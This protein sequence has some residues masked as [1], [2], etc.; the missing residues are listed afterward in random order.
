MNKKLLSI[1]LIGLLLIGSFQAFAFKKDPNIISDKI[2]LSEL[3]VAEIEEFAIIS[4][5]NTT[6][7]LVEDGKPILPQ[8][9]KNYSVPYGS[10][11]T[12]VDVI[13]SDYHKKIIK[14]PI[15]PGLIAIPFG[16]ENDQISI[17]QESPIY[18]DITEF[19]QEKFEYF[20][21]AGRIDN[22]PV[23]LISLY[24]YPVQYEPFKNTVHYYRNIE[25]IIKYSPP[26]NYITYPDEFDLLVIS[27]DDFSSALQPLIDHKN[28][29]GVKSFLKTTEEIYSEYP[30]VDKPEKIKYFIKD[31]LDSYGIKFVLLVGGLKSIFYA[32]P[33]D[34]RNQ[35]TEDWYLPVRYANIITSYDPGLISD[36]YYADIYDSEGNF[37]S[38]DSNEDGLFAS[39]KSFDRNKDIIDLVPEVAVGRLACRN[40]E[41]VNIVVNKIITYETTSYGSEW[42]KNF[43]LV[44][45]DTFD[46]SNNYIEGEIETQKSYDYVFNK[47]YN[48]IRIW[49]SNRDLGGLVPES[50]DIISTI[51][52]GAG[53]V[54]FA[55]HGSPEIWNTH[56]VGGPFERSERAEGIS[57][58]HM[59]KLTNTNEQPIVV[60][61]GC[62]N[63]QFNVTLT[64]FV[65]Y[66]IY[67]LY[68]LTGLEIFNRFE[69]SV[70]TPLPECFSWFFVRQKNGG[71]IATIG[72]TGTG[73]GYTG[74]L[75]DLDG[76]GVDDPDVIEKYGGYIE[77]LFFKSIGVNNVS[78]LGSAW[79]DAITM[80]LAVY[81]G[82]RDQIDAK[83]IE[84]WVL[85]GDPSLKIGG[86]S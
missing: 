29:M 58:Y 1:F 26:R 61:G 14:N 22:N 11:I 43:I 19:P 49:A 62:H 81:P 16:E 52:A 3:Q 15:K 44:G 37:S 47:G 36:L 28:N 69:G 79:Q 60:I 86:Y 24:C 55:G 20:T 18:E 56:W 71:A 17:Q 41:E 83:S 84:Q 74:N 57:W 64:T 46:E 68:E 53:L 63:S 35:G 72:N 48:A 5:S 70:F 7:F 32:K 33:R 9:I 78:Y 76:D 65:N 31:A 23:M 51:S 42:E 66:W 12:F 10:K 54:H 21:S 67:K 40:I 8:I 2:Y 59:M 13:F 82:M 4:F 45:G 6:G 73:I 85:L 27:P 80:Y 34:D 39:F 75:G 25:I 38:W 30:G 77:T 50:E